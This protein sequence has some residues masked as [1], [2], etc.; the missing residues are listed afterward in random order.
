MK[1]LFAVLMVLCVMLTAAAAFAGETNVTT[2][3]WSDHEADAAKIEG[4]FANVAGT[5][6]RMFIPAEF[7]DTEIPKENQDKG[8]IL[9]LKSDKEDKAVVNAQVGSVD[10]ASFKAKLESEGKTVWDMNVN[11]LPGIQFS[12]EAEGVT[13]SC[14]AFSTENGGILM[15]N[16]TLANQE[17]YTGL[18]K[19]MVSSIQ[20]AEQ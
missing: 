19:V 14:F 16:F 1:K 10:I 4:Q 2:V 7:K 18:Y 20:R 17:P 12:V 3:N 13:T 8:T 9:V 11:G 15:F 6:L 5:G